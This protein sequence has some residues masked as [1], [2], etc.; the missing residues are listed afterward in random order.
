MLKHTQSQLSWK[1]GNQRFVCIV[2]R[3]D[4][5]PWQRRYELGFHVAFGEGEI[6]VHIRYEWRLSCPKGDIL[7]E[8]VA[9]P[10]EQ[11]DVAGLSFLVSHLVFESLGLCI[12]ISTKYECHSASDRVENNA[13]L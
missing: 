13:R 1:K 5:V 11:P 3:R 10:E 4:M 12:G 2:R 7:I 9:M 8:D 6:T